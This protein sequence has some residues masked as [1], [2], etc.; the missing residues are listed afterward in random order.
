[1]AALQAYCNVPSIPLNLGPG[2]PQTMIQIVAPANQRVK[3]VGFGFFLDGNNNA[4]TPIEVKVQRQTTAGTG[5]AGSIKP[6]EKELTET[7]QTTT[8]VGFSA[9]PTAE[10]VFSYLDKARAGDP[11]ARYALTRAMMKHDYG[12]LGAAAAPWIARYQRMTDPEGFAQQFAR[13]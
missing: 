5:T 13:Q 11:A 8:L 3:V 2:N 1:M 9:E 4:A 6:N 10:N 12:E 7:I